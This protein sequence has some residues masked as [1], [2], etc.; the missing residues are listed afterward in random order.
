MDTL[1][2]A[3]AHTARTA[4]RL[5]IA[6]TIVLTGVFGAAFG[7]LGQQDQ[8]Q[9]SFSPDNP[10]LEALEFA[11]DAFGGESDTLVQVLV[12]GEDVVGPEGL[13]TVSAVRRVVA[14]TVPAELLGGDPASGG[15]VG[16][17]APVEAALADGGVD[18]SSLDAATI[19]ALYTD[20]LAQLPPELAG[21]TAQLV[22][23]EDP[24]D[25]DAALLLV[26][27]DTEAIVGDAT[28]DDAFTALLDV[29]GPL[30]EAVEE[31]DTPL[32]TQA[33]AF[34]QFFATDDTFTAEV[35][36][37]FGVAALVIV[38]ILLVV[39][40]VSPRGATTRLQ[41]LR[42]GAADTGVTLVAILA[43]ITWMQGIGALLGPDGLGVIGAFSPP[44][45]IIPILLIGLG[46]DYAIHLTSRYREEVAEGAG[47][48]EG[49]TTAVSTVGVA[50]VL[51]TL[52]TVLGFLTNL[53]NPVPAIA[54][55]G[56]LAAVGIAVAFLLMLTFVPAVRLLLDRR[57]EAAG[58]L[59]REALAS[60]AESRLS[61]AMARVSVLAER[62]PAV[63]LAV[64]LAF[65]GLG[66][67]GL[68]QLST[69]FSFADFVPDGSPLKETFLTIEDRFGGGFGE[70]TDVVVRGDVASVA[71]HNATVAA[72]ADLAGVEGVVRFGEQAAATSPVSVLGQTL[73]VAQLAQDPTAAE[74]GGPGAGGAPPVDPR[75]AASVASVASA[76]GVAP[77]LTFPDGADVAA[78]Y[79]ALLDAVPSASAVLAREPGG[80]FTASLV[81][82][83]TQSG[84]VGGRE[85]AAAIDEA[86]GPVEAAG[87]DVVPTSNAIVTAV[88][89]GELSDSQ[90]SSLGVTLI[91][92][93]L[94]LVVVFGVRERRPELGLVTLL[95]VA[96]VVLWV[97]GTMAATGI[98]FGPVTATISAL[99]IGV[100]VPFTIHITHRFTEELHR[101]DSLEEA[102]RA[103]MRHTGG[104]LAGSAFTTMAGFA[105]LVTSSLPPFRQ[106]GLVVAYAIG[107]SLLSAVV[108]LPSLLAL[109]ARWR[110]LDAGAGEPVEVPVTAA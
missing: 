50:L 99:A 103:T 42:R 62:A 98:P 104:A 10:A 87:A 108:V 109:W 92:S 74:E 11:G 61:G 105:V 79:A 86:F 45:Q 46:V 34:E 110:H 101:Q 97:F 93:L 4:P 81:E 73:A 35:G 3:L 85:L 89:I 95:P 30:V 78:V 1:V 94:L 49:A 8:G 75:A 82:V 68:T 55:F 5:V 52:T 66:A 65:G 17:L 2:R 91:A 39:Y 22:A 80:A 96:L 67:Y 88:I 36:R 21:L 77:D 31:A 59:P 24:L 18:P 13:A 48:D 83:Q 26:F 107:Y 63:V 53:F 106:L 72:Q 9:E 90:V 38:L 58:R 7:A 57:A 32:S 84:E 33:F 16:Y 76:E 40:A 14:R 64:T 71:V 28:G 19:D 102:L 12:E 56:V 41:S 70:R 69:E 51:A 27:L 43:S 29:I 37:L 60:N 15:V 6:L 54:D 23:G 20:G 47:V 25:S 44:T 100:G